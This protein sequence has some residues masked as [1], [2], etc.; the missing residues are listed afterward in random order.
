MTTIKGLDLIVR[1]MV[2]PDLTVAEKAEAAADRKK[3]L[4]EK[5]AGLTQQDIGDAL[6]VTRVA[7]FYWENGQRLPAGDMAV[8]YLSLLREAC[9]AV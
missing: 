8:R 2:L 9:G 7:V 5:Q 4:E 6:G 3:A 1:D